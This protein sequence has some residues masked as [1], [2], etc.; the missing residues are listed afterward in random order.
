MKDIINTNSTNKKAIMSMNMNS[1]KTSHM[2]KTYKQEHNSNFV[3][4]LEKKSRLKFD[5]QAEN[6][7]PQNMMS[8]LPV[9]IEENFGVDLTYSQSTSNFLASD[10]FQNINLLNSTGMK[11]DELANKLLFWPKYMPPRIEKL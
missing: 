7:S 2:E 1:I 9:Q 10:A 11:T 4:T 8:M 5:S 6:T 3:S